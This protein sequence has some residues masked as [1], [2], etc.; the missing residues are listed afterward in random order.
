M[1]WVNYIVEDLG[2]KAGSGKFPQVITLK[3]LSEEYGISATPIRKAIDILIAKGV[4]AKNSQN[5]LSIGSKKPKKISRTKPLCPP[6]DLFDFLARDMAI[7]SLAGKEK[8]IREDAVAKKYKV[9]RTVIRRIFSKLAGAGIIDHLPRIGWRLRP[10][11]REDL[12]AFL[13]VRE[14]L[15]LKAM[16][17]AG[18]KLEIKTLEK[19]LADNAA[20]ENKVDNSLHNYIIEKSANRYIKDF[21]EH[22]GKYY[23]I[24]FACEDMDKKSSALAAE[25]HRKILTALINRDYLQAKVALSDHIHTNHDVL[26]TKPGL[27]LKLVKRIK[28]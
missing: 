26:N 10:F 18:D 2:Q 15:E 21:F 7:E 9:S 27:I 24:L 8:F 19:F 14:I 17:L 11:C 12:A 3:S 1:T 16:E 6:V 13:Q 20:Q 25:Q 23:E 4:I 5:R 22:Y 28:V